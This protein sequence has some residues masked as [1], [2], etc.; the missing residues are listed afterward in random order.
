MRP[1]TEKTARAGE[2]AGSFFERGD[3]VAPGNASGT[4]NTAFWAVRK[5]AAV[6]V[7]A[8][9]LAIAPALAEGARPSAPEASLF[10]S[11]MGDRALAVLADEKLSNEGRTTSLTS[12]LDED[13]ELDAIARFVVGDA[14]SSATPEQQ[15]AYRELFRAYV[16]QKYSAMFG[17]YSG[18]RFVVSRAEDVGERDVMVTGEIVKDGESAVQTDWRVRTF[19]GALKI[20][21]VKVAGVSMLASQR[22]E[23]TSVIR[24]RGFDGLLEM[25]R[26]M[27]SGTP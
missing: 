7:G 14:W 16:A 6:L 13:F 9:L 19:E 21:D 26:N 18:Q 4:M 22:A 3:A 17:S 23:F 27:T 10:I 2:I 8:M 5:G 1:P 15:T 11:E 12:M 20:V 25:L 24:E